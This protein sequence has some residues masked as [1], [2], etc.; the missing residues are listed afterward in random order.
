MS[1]CK[2]I[3]G[4]PSS[5][6][7][8]P[9]KYISLVLFQIYFRHCRGR[10]ISSHNL[11]IYSTAF[12]R[13]AE[14][15]SLMSNGTPVLGSLLILLDTAFVTYLGEGIIHYRSRTVSPLVTTC[16]SLRRQITVAALHTEL[17][18]LFNR[19]S[20]CSYLYRRTSFNAHRPACPP[21][22]HRI[23]RTGL[24]LKI[25]VANCCPNHRIGSGLDCAVSA[26]VRMVLMP[27]PTLSA[28][29]VYSRTTLIASLISPPD[30][31][32]P[33]WLSTVDNSRRVPMAGT[34]ISQ[35]KAL[36]TSS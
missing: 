21:N 14:A 9:T 19:C 22:T 13:T 15:L 17:Q 6:F 33:A 26:V 18:V 7:P 35:S 20:P 28:A 11:G 16:I 3:S 23:Y 31:N 32:M 10:S 1:N 24:Y 25:C 27:T 34:G 5:C 30:S 2:R 36:V 4:P 12:P 29:E 8:D